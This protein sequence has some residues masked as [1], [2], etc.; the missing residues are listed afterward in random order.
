MLRADCRH[1]A[2]LL[3]SPNFGDRRDG[4]RPDLLLLHYTGMASAALAIDW[5]RR[6]ES[7]VSSHYVIDEHGCITQLVAEAKRA[8]HAGVGSWHGVRDINSC[9]IGIEIH[10]PGHDRGYPD[11]PEA[12]MRSVETLSRDII[13]RW[14]MRPERVLAHSDIAPRRK[15]DPG[16]KFDWQRLHRAGIGHWVAPAS[17]D[18]GDC[19]LGPGTK[20][21]WVAEAQLLLARY[22]YQIA[23][24]GMLDA[25]TCTV[26]TA[27]QRHFR[28]ARVDGRL[29]RATLATLSNLLA[30]L[31][32]PGS[33]VKP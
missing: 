27:F 17:P 4:C 30:A 11:F 23:Q 16:E 28:P 1:D 14:E 32:T 5:L 7:R 33:C 2:R 9:S 26:L 3:P 29:D 25:E 10:N 22:G 6:P 13:E 19:G 20:D 21:P 24:T 31:T 18:R 12:Q 15:I 8:W